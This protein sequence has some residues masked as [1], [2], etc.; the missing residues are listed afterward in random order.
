MTKSERTFVSSLDDTQI[1]STINSKTMPNTSLYVLLI[2]FSLDRCCDAAA[3][4]RVRLVCSV[5][6]TA[7]AVLHINRMIDRTMFHTDVEIP[8]TIS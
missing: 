6:A 3:D 8:F 5:A 2:M 1:M 7:A 4:A